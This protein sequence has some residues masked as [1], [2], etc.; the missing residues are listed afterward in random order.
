MADFTVA[1]NAHR[2][3]TRG[4]LKAV[5]VGLV[6]VG[7]VPKVANIG[8]L[9]MLAVAG[10]HAPRCL[11]GQEEHQEDNDKSAHERDGWVRTELG[12]RMW[13]EC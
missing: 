5:R 13:G 4:L 3:A 11:Q 7:V 10:G 1:I 6:L 9:L 12:P 2:S 8:P